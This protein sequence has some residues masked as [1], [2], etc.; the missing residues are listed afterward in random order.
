MKYLTLIF[1]LSSLSLTG[2]LDFSTSSKT[3]DKSSKLTVLWN[4]AY[5]PDGGAPSVKPLIHEGMVITSGDIN[6]TSLDYKTGELMW[7]TSFE[8]H[9]QLTNKTFGLN[10]NVLVGNITKKT[11]AWNAVTGEQLWETSFE[12]S[13]SWSLSRGIT[14]SNSYF[15]FGSQGSNLY[16][17]NS[18]GK[19]SIEKLNARTYETTVINNVLFAGQRKGDEG[20]VSAYNI[21]TMELLW[22]FN[23][24]NFGFFSREAPIVE[25]GIVY[26]GTTGGLTG[27]RN[28]FFALNAQ[29]GEEIWR[30]EGIFTYS[31]VLVGD[32]LYVNDAAGIYKLRK[33][34]GGI[35]WYSD[36][37]A[38]AGTGPIAYGYG[39][40]YAP[41]SGTMHIVDA[42][43]GEIVQRVSPPHGNWF[44]LVTAAN[45]RIFAQSS[46]HLYAFAPWGHKLPLE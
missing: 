37:Q 13:L 5:D 7:K 27:S 30:R 39:Y 42:Q 9:M 15:L 44:W 26:V 8:H 18:Q 25:N 1:L 11:M 34:D 14:T 24:G 22:S 21:L 31:A 19:L 17:L 10:E 28:G 36:F 38:G 43:S 29:T 23:P 12:D 35:E 45:G 20:I 32:Y 3:N 41:H 16:T 46:S 4:Y 40:L 6:V 33:S 2:C